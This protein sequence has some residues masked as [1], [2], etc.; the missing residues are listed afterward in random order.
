VNERVILPTPTSI[1]TAH[2]YHSHTA[3]RQI[4]KEKVPETDP[5]YQALVKTLAHVLVDDNLVYIGKNN[6]ETL[7]QLATKLGIDDVSSDDLNKLLSLNPPIIEKGSDA[8]QVPNIPTKV[9]TFSYT[10]HQQGIFGRRC[11]I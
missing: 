3:T 9:V 8:T 5:E 1:K 2:R 6:L 7:H 10:A 11:D 4:L